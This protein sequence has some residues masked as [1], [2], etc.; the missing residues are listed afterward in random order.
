VAERPATGQHARVRLLALTLVATLFTGCSAGTSSPAARPDASD[1]ASDDGAASHTPTDLRHPCELVT[2]RVAQQVLG[3][4]VLARRVEEELAPRTL[5]CSYRARSRSAAGPLLEIRS[6]PDPRSLDVLVGLY[7]GGDRLPHHP[8]DVAGADDAELVSDPS[9]GLV[10]VFA[11]QGFVTHVVVLTP[12]GP[13]GA[14][15]GEAD[16]AERGAVS[17]AGTV[18]AGNR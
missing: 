15:D 2:P 4:P 1:L 5:D 7:L 14:L 11:K 17:L 10:T 8:V 12:T 9:R 18:V 16:G 6:T 13:G 3:V